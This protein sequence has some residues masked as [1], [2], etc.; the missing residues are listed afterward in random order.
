MT[1]NIR[2]GVNLA[3]SLD[4]RRAA[5]SIRASGAAIVLLQEVCDGAVTLD[6][7]VGT[8]FV[9]PAAAR[10]AEHARVAAAAARGAVAA[11]ATN[12]QV[13]ALRQLL[14]L[15]WSGH[16]FAPHDAGALGVASAGERSFGIG[17]LLRDDAAVA[18]EVRTHRFA[19]FPGRLGRG[20]LAVRFRAAAVAA[21]G[22]VAGDGDNGGEQR[23]AWAVCTHMQHDV[24]GLE[25]EAQAE[26][27]LAF[28]S[29]LRSGGGASTPAAVLLPAIVG[30]D[31]NSL[32]R[33]YAVR[34]L[35]SALGGGRP[36]ACT[37]PLFPLLGS[38]GLVLDYLFVAGGARA[39]REGAIEVL[40]GDCASDHFPVCCEV[41][42]L[43]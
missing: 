23:E 38:A 3:G 21:S 43:R 36:P 2:V 16:Y 10:L 8:T 1:F 41:A 14:P 32:P 39:R 18:L 30:G 29:A 17:V 4:L 42:L 20:A 31:L 11:G 26:E 25:Q 5:A 9:G 34:R 37:F 33:S 22:A 40:S 19:V 15:G 6:G 7:W 24:T 13:E 35:E 27:L 12:D 28:V